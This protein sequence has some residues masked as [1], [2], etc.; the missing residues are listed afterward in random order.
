MTPPVLADIN[1]DGV[2]DII[3]AMFNSTVIAFDGFNFR[4]I[5]NYS[6]PMSESYN[7]PA[8]GYFNADDIPDFLVKYQHGPGFPIYYYSQVVSYCIF[9]SVMSADQLLHLLL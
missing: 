6:F 9:K 4:Q 5:W 3:M 7:T 2:E 1:G 8:A